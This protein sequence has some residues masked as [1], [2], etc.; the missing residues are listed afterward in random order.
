MNCQWILQMAWRDSRRNKSRLVLFISSIILGIAALVAIYGLG[1][2][3]ERDIDLQAKTLIGADL[4]VDANQPPDP[5]VQQLLDSIGTFSQQAAENNFAS[6]IYFTKSGGTRLAQVRA[7]SG[8]FPF[9]GQLETRPGTAF[10]GF[11]KQQGALVERT[12]LLQFNAQPGDSIRVGE[13][14]F[15]ILGEILQSPGKT[16]FSAAVAPAVWIP[17]EALD[18]TGLLQKG[19]RINYLYY[20]KFP[21]ASTINQLLPKIENRLEEAGW[22]LETVASRKE[23]TGRSFR[24]LNEFLQLVSFIALLLGCIGVASAIHIYVREKISSI[25]I[26]KCLGATNRQ[27]F[28]IY[29]VQMLAIGLLGSILGAFLGTGIQFLLPQV[30]KDF[31]PIEIHMQVSWKAIGQGI[32]VGILVSLLFALWPLLGVRKVSPLNTLR[33][34]GSHSRWWQ[35]GWR[36]L[37]G[38]GIIVFIFGF[39]WLQTGTLQAATGFT[40][41]VILSF[42]LL[43]GAAWLLIYLIR[44]YFPNQLAYVWRQGFANLFRPNNQTV[45]LVVAIGLGTSFICLLFYIQEVLTSKV[46]RAGS[47]NQPN[48]VVFDIQP[49]QKEAL[50]QLTTSYNLP[51]I[52]DVPIITMRLS[53]IRGYSAADLK[54]DTTIDIPRRAFDGEIRAT[55]RDSLTEAET[56]LE[57]ELQD[58]VTNLNDIRISI[59]EGYAKR[60]KVKPGDKL[61]FNVQ[62]APIKTTVGSLRT[63][64]WNRVQTNFR[65]IFPK[66]ILEQA[67]KFHVLVTRVPS[68]E[69]SAKYQRALVES[70]PTVSV[71]DLNLI[72]KTVDDILGKISFVIQFI[73][74]FSI[75]TGI[76]VLIASILISKYQRMQETVLLRTI[77]ATNRQVFAITALEYFFLGSLAA[78]TGIGLALI[79]GFLLAKFSFDTGFNPPLLATG[80]IFLSITG[81]TVLIGLFNSRSVL[82]APPLSILNSG[83]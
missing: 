57:G 74:G 42:L 54:A 51:I 30:L 37:V 8:G 35:D 63:V 68:P 67:P 34:T 14:T 77:G 83:T 9:Y 50:N 6:M 60:L 79:G 73:G 32:L 64:D 55:Y 36:L 62:G 59:E 16:G 21:S 53:S 43:S 12:L 24:D 26:L 19:S 72:L 76:M 70:F 44:R 75:I 58:S 22:D 69:F 39:S 65:V 13:K 45:I 27:S 61:E 15:L 17:L 31:L 48:L 49:S 82:K 10:A 66:G 4:A 40:I 33:V 5:V 41:G 7:V 38:V 81:L 1:Y 11:A 56:I 25:A 18:E 20:Y 29:L 47:D 80:L 28:L 46:Q 23:S 3:L 52:Q 78:I 71:I 2:T